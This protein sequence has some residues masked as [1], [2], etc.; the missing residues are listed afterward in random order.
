MAARTLV[1]VNPKSRS[2]ATRRRLARVLAALRDA[3]GPLEVE[4]TRGPRDA[5]R[6]AREGVRAGIERIVVAGGDG[7]ASEVVTGLLAAELGRYAGIAVLPLGTGA[8]WIRTLGV[9]RELD[10]AVAAIAEGRE[11]ALDAGRV[12]FRDRDGRERTTYFANIT[13]LG[14]SALVTELVNRTTKAFGGRAS[15]LVGTLRGIARYRPRPVA[16]RLDGA[17]VH[18]G[19]LVLAAV[20]NGRFFGGGMQIA[21]RAVPDD[22]LLDL[23]FVPDVGA[24]RLLRDLPRLYAGTHLELPEVGSRRGRRVDAEAEPGSVWIEVDG[25]PLGTLPASVEVLP[26]ALRVLGSG[27]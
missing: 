9:P 14:V 3:L 4:A 16:L 26:G 21:P 5:E 11:R 18:E 23:V 24:L 13:S 22:G 19:P 8:D 12:R 25:E 1:V 6:I 2:G 17:L 20:A 10:R 27:A 7:T 15:F